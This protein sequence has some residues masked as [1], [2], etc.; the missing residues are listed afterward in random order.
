MYAPITKPIATEISVLNEAYV[1]FFLKTDATTIRISTAETAPKITSPYNFKSSVN[2]GKL[3]PD[4]H[5]NAMPAV[6]K[7]A[8]IT[9]VFTTAPEK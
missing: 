7:I 4:M 9:I 8:L 5:E 3:E 6:S 2:S 1:E